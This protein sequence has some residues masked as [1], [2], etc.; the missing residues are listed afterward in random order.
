MLERL[1]RATGVELDAARVRYLH[2]LTLV[3]C[4]FFAINSCIAFATAIV[5]SREAWV[6]YNGLISY[7]I[8]GSI[9]L[10]ERL[11]R[12]WV[13]RRTTGTSD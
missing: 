13:L 5:G 11:V 12:Q 8:A 10:G 4:G 3:W 6:V 1:V 9:F 7:L 2:R